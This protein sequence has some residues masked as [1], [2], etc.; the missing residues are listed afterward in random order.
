M[1]DAGPSPQ[2]KKCG[3]RLQ[4]VNANSHDQRHTD[5]GLESPETPT[6]PHS[7]WARWL[8]MVPPR[9][10]DRAFWIQRRQWWKV[11]AHW[12]SVWSSSIN[13]ITTILISVIHI[14]LSIPRLCYWSHTL[15]THP[16]TGLNLVYVHTRFSGHTNTITYLLVT[17]V[18][19]ALGEILC[20]VSAAKEVESHTHKH[21]E[22]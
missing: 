20:L 17:K 6:P 22:Q 16:G 21:A 7:E 13:A 15:I 8:C 18:C 4:R 14:S 19:L 3:S 1:P 9:H 11:A 5:T 10:E 12:S 2:K